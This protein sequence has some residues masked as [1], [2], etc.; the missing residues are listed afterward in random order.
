MTKAYEF[1]WIREVP[2]QLQNGS[3]LEIFFEV[4]L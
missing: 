4:I 3:Y 2:E 1:N